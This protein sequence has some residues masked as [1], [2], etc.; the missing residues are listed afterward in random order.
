[1]FLYHG[2]YFLFSQVDPSMSIQE[3]GADDVT[4]LRMAF[5][6]FCQ[7]NKVLIHKLSYYHL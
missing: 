1:M 3:E 6:Q 5:L 2:E 7:G 4:V